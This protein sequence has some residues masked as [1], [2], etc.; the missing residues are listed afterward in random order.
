MNNLN[1]LRAIEIWLTSHIW[2]AH[3]PWCIIMVFSCPIGVVVFVAGERCAADSNAVA[4]TPLSRHEAR[5][6]EMDETIERYC[7]RFIGTVLLIVLF[8]IL[9]WWGRLSSG[10]SVRYPRYRRPAIFQRNR[11]PQPLSINRQLISHLY[12][13]CIHRLCRA[14]VF[15]NRPSAP[16]PANLTQEANPHALDRRCSRATKKKTSRPLRR[17]TRLHN[18]PPH[19]PMSV[20]LCWI[21]FFLY[22]PVGSSSL[23]CF[24]NF[25]PSRSV[26]SRR[27]SVRT[28]TRVL[29]DHFYEFYFL[30]KTV[31]FPSPTRH[32]ASARVFL[33]LFF[34]FLSFVFIY[35]FFS[36]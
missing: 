11:P 13:H 34:K 18:Y 17:P 10:M 27:F 25:L 1:F 7:K 35:W 26:S 6:K 4:D 16:R 3:H 15:E 30:S 5:I 12:R 36:K 8:W 22:S 28:R 33:H 14:I 24:R 23:I 31:A 19:K 32:N 9:F 21:F 20:V 29:L 2:H